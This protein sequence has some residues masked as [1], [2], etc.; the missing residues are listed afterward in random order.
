M[1]DAAMVLAPAR[2]DVVFVS[3]GALC[4]LPHVARW[5]EQVGGLLR[6]GGRLYLHEGHPL[7]GALAQDQLHVEHSYFEEAEPLI[8][9]SGV[10]YADSTVRLAN[11]ASHEWN[12]SVGEIVNAV[13]GAG[14]SVDLLVEHDW[15]AWPRFPWLERTDDG[16]WRVPA[17][18][19]RVPLSLTLVATAT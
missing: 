9:T 8:D 6:R 1:L 11:A 5:A 10:T 7:A 19:P 18:R 12:H 2:F 4:W 13:I 15:T 17:S 16:R 14:L 3:L